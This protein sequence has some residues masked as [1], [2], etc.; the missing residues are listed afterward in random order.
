[1]VDDPGHVGPRIDPHWFD[2]ARQVVMFVLG[3]WMI[4]YAAVS[5]GH[6]IPFLVV[7][8][9]LFGMI[10]VERLAQKSIEQKEK[11]DDR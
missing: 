8:L 3:V 5:Q 2:V 4:V 10:P 1:M 11:K 6:D 9:I 7:G